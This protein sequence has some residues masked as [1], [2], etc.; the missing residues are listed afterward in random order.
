MDSSK[1]GAKVPLKIVAR[2]FLSKTGRLMSQ[3]RFDALMAR[4]GKD[5]L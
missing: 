1:Y 2:S 3:H 5:M 4:K